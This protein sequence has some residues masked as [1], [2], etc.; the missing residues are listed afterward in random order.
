[1][2]RV[3]C[4]LRGATSRTPSQ[5]AMMAIC[6]LR[7]TAAAGGICEYLDVCSSA[8]R[9]FPQNPDLSSSRIKTEL[10]SE[11]MAGGHHA[12]LAVVMFPRSHW[13]QVLVCGV[14]HRLR[15]LLPST[16]LCNDTDRFKK[17]QA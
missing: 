10:L 6:E 9:R 14:A 16:E 12:G 15:Y 1:M 17:R 13:Q 5:L 3:T 4:T 11:V 7:S 2:K 8:G